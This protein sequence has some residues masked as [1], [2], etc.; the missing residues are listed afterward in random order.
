MEHTEPASDPLHLASWI[1]RP[2]SPRGKVASA[3]ASGDAA[4][5]VFRRAFSL[6]AAPEPDRAAGGSI[7]LRIAGLGVHAIRVNGV[8]VG[9]GA[10]EPAISDP[11]RVIYYSRHDVSSLL[12][13]GRNTLEVTLGRGFF[14]MATPN[15]W[16]WEKAPWR[17]DPRLI[18][19]L[20][21]DDTEDILLVSDQ[22]W[23]C[24][25]GPIRFD[26]MYEGE[27]YDDRC[28]PGDWS[29]VAVVQGPGG[30]LVE[31]PHEPVV[32][33]TPIRPSWRGSA[34]GW[35]GDLG[36][37]IAGVA[38]YDL[39]LAEGRQLR[40]RFGE[41]LDRE[42]NLTCAN[43]H[44]HTPR[45]QTDLLIGAGRR[46]YWQPEFSYKGF[47]YLCVEGLERCPDPGEITA[48]PLVQQ[49]RPAVDFHCDVPILNRLVTMMSTTVLNNL[50]HIPTDTPI[51]EKNGWTGD[52]LVAMDSMSGLFDLRELFTKWLDDVAATQLPSGQLSVIAPSPGWGY[53]PG[54]CAPAPEWSCILPGMLMHL[55]DVYGDLEPAG[56]H[57]ECLGRYL[58]WELSRLDDD[59][60]A[61]SEL[62]DYLSPGYI[63]GP[64]PE[65]TRLSASC[66]L[67]RGL[68]QAA[69]LAGRLHRPD[70]FSDAAR[71][72]AERINGVFLDPVRCCYATSLDPSAS[73][74]RDG[75]YRQTSN[76]MPLAFGIVPQAS[77][78]A[79]LESLVDDVHGR[80]HHLNT[81]HIGTSLLLNVLTD[82]GFGADAFLIATQ[83]SCPSWGYWIDQ[84]ATTMW[85]RWDAGAR[86]RDHFFQGTVADWILTRVAGVQRVAPDWAEVRIRPGLVDGVS[87]CRSSR[88]TSR[89]RLTV[90]WDLSTRKLHLVVPE[91]MVCRVE[92][93]AG[94][95]E[96][97]AGDVGAGVIEVGPGESIWELLP[98]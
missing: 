26:S 36:Q 12:R 54:E 80:H 73:P 84:G 63:D 57:W 85:E 76:L 38:R 67:Y 77:R 60:L 24:G 96:D 16:R 88:L 41:K 91:E 48:I 15:A 87:Q 93:G 7:V 68:R 35:I 45:F 20:T 18:C 94:G 83:R 5:P 9:V 97:P 3:D 52:V 49:V 61:R 59:G 11:R 51:F 70:E 62:G 95:G 66:F 19:A 34:A 8:P 90:E 1:S 31:R 42:G 29:P 64:P 6:D 86:S 2:S 79:V 74:A 43:E 14:N 46:L 47:R 50:H 89:G 98:A 28:T 92:L 33:G 37:M 22:S 55:A 17:A 21:R 27:T 65:D 56:R 10:L 75:E 4:A 30:R 53:L 13:P 78:Q 32:P 69:E 44:V 71:T 25:E 72:L 81:G 82:A 39:P 58:R 23:I 40:V